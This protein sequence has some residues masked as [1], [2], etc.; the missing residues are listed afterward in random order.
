MIIIF[1]SYEIAQGR[2]CETVP[3]SVTWDRGCLLHGREFGTH[4]VDF[5]WKLKMRQPLGHGY[6]LI[7]SVQVMGRE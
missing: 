1:L 2:T 6:W 3:N 5:L 4:S 7:I